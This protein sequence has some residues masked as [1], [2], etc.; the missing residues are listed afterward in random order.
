MTSL[1]PIQ[2]QMN[3]KLPEKWRHQTLPAWW[4]K[5][6]DLVRIRKAQE[7]G[8]KI[9]IET[10]LFHLPV[11]PTSPPPPQPIFKLLALRNASTSFNKS[12]SDP[13]RFNSSTHFSNKKPSSISLFSSLLKCLSESVLYRMAQAI[14]IED[15]RERTQGI[16]EWR[17]E[18]GEGNWK[19]KMMKMEWNRK[20]K[21]RRK[22]IEDWSLLIWVFFTAVRRPI[23]SD[24]FNHCFRRSLWVGLDAIW[25]RGWAIGESCRLQARV[26]LS[27]GRIRR[28]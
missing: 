9:I 22:M 8:N 16:Q 10:S 13:L 18:R 27:A 12:N 1:I 5:T 28:S 23:R 4:R 25:C 3:L 17:L 14:A 11:S 2:K 20:K 24:S 6:T 7:A 19:R 26:F 21:Q 15:S